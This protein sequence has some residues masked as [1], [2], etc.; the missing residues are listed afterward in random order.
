[1]VSENKKLSRQIARAAKR[2]GEYMECPPEVIDQALAR[3]SKLS[4][5][6][7][8][9]KRLGELLLDEKA[10]TPEDLQAAIF[11][12]RLD[13]LQ[14]CPLF[15][16]VSLGELVK[17]R[18]WVSEKSVGVGEEFITQDV[19]G[20][21]FYVLVSGR[22]VVVRRGEFGEEIPL[23]H[24]EHG[25]CIG[26]MGYFADGRR[27]ASVRALEESELLKI[28]YDDLEM[29]YQV[30][31]T[32]TK[33]FLDLVTDRLRRTN[34]AFQ[35]TVLRSRR[36]ERSL[37]SLYKFLD[38]SE[39]LTLR[40][41]I[42][43]LIERVVSTASKVMNA[44]RATLFLLDSF[45]GELWSKV[46]HGLQNRE[47]RIPVGQGIA[48]W[49]AKHDQILSIPDAYADPR[50]DSSS[51]RRTGYRTKSIL[52]GPVKS[53]Q[54]EIVGVIQVINRK[55][56][57]AFEE[58]DEAHFK[59]FAYQTAITVE[60]FHLYQKLVGSH[61]K[62][63]VLLD[64]ATSVAQTLDLDALIIRIVEK[65]SQ[66]LQAERSSL[67]LLDRETGELWSK[68]A[69]GSELAEIRFPMSMGLA[70]SVAETGQALNIK[71]AYQDPRFNPDVDRR[72]GFR[73]RG[74]LCAPIFNR[75]G[76]VMGVTQAVNKKGGEFSQE[77]EDLLRA[78]S[79]QIGVA[80]ENAQLY[81]R[82][83]SMKN[84]LASVQ[85][86]ISNGILTLDGDYR[87]MTANR[88]AA[89]LLQKEEGDLTKRDFRE[90][91]GQGNDRLTG[92]VEQVQTAQ[93]SVLDY[94]VKLVLPTGKE[95]TLNVNFVPLMDH[96]GERQGSVLVLEDITLERRLKGTMIRYMAK[97]IVE[98]LIE[99]PSQQALGGVRSKATVLFSDIRGFTGMAENFT[100]EQTVEFL[101]AYFSLMVEEIFEHGG[102]LDKYIGDAIMAVFGV[103]FPHPNDAMRAVQT[104]LDMRAALASFNSR[105]MELGY[106]PISIG[107]GICTAE[108]ISGNIGSERRMD[109]TVVGDGVNVASRL[110]SLT[111][112]YGTNILI[113][114]S[115][116]QEVQG[117][118]TTRVV[119]QVVVKG[120]TKPVQIFEVL[121]EP[122]VAPSPPDQCFTDGLALYHRREFERAAQAFAQGAQESRLCKVYLGRCLH[123]QGNPPPPEWNG[124]W[125][126]P[127]K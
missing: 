121:G 124:V 64:V 95:H 85:E 110:E 30:A 120:K 71:D 104:A 93:F 5:T 7:T 50:F 88:A 10:I 51:D 57:S 41:G 100:A 8:Q 112:Y 117:G 44:D 101:N 91:L 9:K 39:I 82:T 73:T 116:H 13:R 47:I 49:V 26:E 114:E 108:V 62:M 48:G 12:Q 15:T 102:V 53:L 1:M 34:M 125:V 115:T 68:V 89:I 45:T 83:V 97:D 74:V 16:G 60:N 86:S 66:V 123:F 65:V 106:M 113:S 55:D 87:V 4:D 61:E 99:D 28:N 56:G 46:A 69:Q 122:G 79:S 126:S 77:D 6:L 32:L 3:Q 111:K 67:F 19:P 21:C 118:F 20:D 84:Y 63:A 14:S 54:G 72:T 29:I 22:A 42:E 59:A 18:D 119:D 31:P 52:C 92:L 35:E 127:E 94:D 76:Q 80:L 25:E 11:R 33:N 90:V 27:T 81:A 103:P 37:E 58:A 24:V 78:F 23:A 75:E 40:A 70:G 98:R 2:L 96:K 105:R 107:I 43:G 109:F 38:M 36:A 17:I